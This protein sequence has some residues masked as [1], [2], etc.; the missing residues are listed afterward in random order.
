M[1]RR[2][3]YLLPASLR[4]AARWLFYLPY[5]LV[6]PPPPLVP[7]RRLIFTGRGPFVRQGDEWLAFFRAEGLQPHQ[8]FLDIGSGIGR[9]AR[10]LTGYL[11]GS[12]E[13]FDVVRTG[14]R[15]CQ[16]NITSLYPH[17]RFTCVP[18]YNDLYTSHGDRADKFK[19]PYENNR[20][21]FACAISVFTHLLPDETWNYLLESARVLRP[22][23]RLVATFF[24][25]RSDEE[26]SRSGVFQFPFV[27]GHYALMSRRVKRANVAYRF[28][29][30][31]KVSEDCGFRILKTIEGAWKGQQM[32]HPVAF[33]DVWVLERQSAVKH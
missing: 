19:F 16:K 22:G 26:L 4:F 9:I 30:L 17:F 3:Y 7:P 12:Y 21:H 2:L 29:F 5:D 13:G 14:V 6:N 27:H 1:W 8:N 18:L 28:D 32:H 10:P 20:F 31:E 11:V 23:G 24:V 15:W 33:Q 25:F